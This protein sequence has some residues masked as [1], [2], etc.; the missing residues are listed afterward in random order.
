MSKR[1]ASNPK[2]PPKSKPGQ[3]VIVN[4]GGGYEVVKPDYNPEKDWSFKKSGCYNK[5]LWFCS[6]FNIIRNI[7]VSPTRG[8]YIMA[9]DKVRDHAIALL[10]SIRVHDRETPV[11]LIPY[12]DRYQ[13]VAAELAHRFSVHLFPDLDLLDRINRGVTSIF[14]KDTFPRP[15]QFRKQACWFG[16]FE[17][18]L[19]IDTDIIVFS[20]IVQCL[21]FLDRAD[22]ICMDHQRNGGIYGIFS[23]SV[24]DEGV[25]T[26]HH[27]REIFNAGFWGGKR[28]AM[29]EQKLFEALE[30]GARN[31]R[32]FD[33]STKKAS[34]MPVFN[35]LVIKHF[36]RKLNLVDV[37]GYRAGSW[38][39]TRGYK[40][41]KWGGLF[42]PHRKEA[43]HYM[44]WA[45]I[46]IQPGYPY[47]RIWARYRLMG[48]P[49]ERVRVLENDLR[50]TWALIK[51]R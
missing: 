45:G 21:D 13:E 34:D 51:N 15:N 33:F 1:K 24:I 19:Y 18:F 7:M 11:V 4:P 17:E 14:G 5:L 20:R 3:V 36:T 46:K 41:I 10:N 44:H 6:D 29:S 2:P 22:F 40:W 27:L 30:D 38:A 37:I 28:S 8:I 16:P 39:G 43:L 12:D 25:L 35:W 23:Q 31:M 26:E 9:N 50:H 42:D 49:S 32:Y 47:W 48:D